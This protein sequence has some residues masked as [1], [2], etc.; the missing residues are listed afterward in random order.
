MSASYGWLVAFTLI[1]GIGYGVRIALVPG[2]LIEFFGLQRLGA[3]LG[4]FFTATGVASLLGPL[5]AGLI[6]DFTGDVYWGVV[7][8][9]A[10]GLLGFLAILPL[11]MPDA[12]KVEGAASLPACEIRGTSPSR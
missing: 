4:I 7:F 11:R 6:I 2:L 8:A 10:M 5:F 12:F 1:L 3:M 9:L